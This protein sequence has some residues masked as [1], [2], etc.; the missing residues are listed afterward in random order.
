MAKTLTIKTISVRE[1]LSNIKIIQ[2]GLK[3]NTTRGAYT[4]RYT[5]IKDR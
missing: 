2:K 1:I 3:L 5:L 4:R